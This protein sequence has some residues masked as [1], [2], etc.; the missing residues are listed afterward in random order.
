ML[1]A[2]GDWA[3]LE[4][5]LGKGVGM[6]LYSSPEWRMSF[7]FLH[8]SWLSVNITIKRLPFY[9]VSWLTGKL[10]ICFNIPSQKAGPVRNKWVL[11]IYVRKSKI[12]VG[13][14]NGLCHSIW[15]ASENI[16]CD[17][18]LWKISTLL[19]LLIWIYF[20]VGCSPTKSKFVVFCL[21]TRFPPVWFV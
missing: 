17:L 5:S 9:G 12:L 15:E 19:S 2:S 7:I 18:R 16:G 20:V 14:S 21:C 6:D 3:P 4:H 13:K 8:L 10:F 11:T 1:F